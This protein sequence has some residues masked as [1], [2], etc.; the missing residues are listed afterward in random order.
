[1]HLRKSRMKANGRPTNRTLQAQEVSQARQRERMS[2]AMISLAET[3]SFVI[4]LGCCI[5]DQPIFDALNKP[6]TPSS[7]IR[8]GPVLE[9]AKS[10]RFF[11][12]PQSERA[13]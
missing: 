3:K 8:P 10:N 1:M 11:D 2:S 6:Q 5:A 9:D 13:R 7:N 12:D 4:W